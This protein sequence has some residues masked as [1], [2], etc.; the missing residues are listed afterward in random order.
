M[1]IGQY[2]LD[3]DGNPVP[4]LDTLEWARWFEGAFRRVAFTDLG[5]VLGQVSTVFLG[6]DHNFNPMRDPLSYRPVL[7]ETM[8][9][10]GLHDGEMCRYDSLEAAQR[11]HEAMVQRCMEV[12]DERCVGE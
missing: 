10:G 9:F 1:W 11:G 3:A 6:L 12:P 5:E 4:C 7:W 2:I 8:V